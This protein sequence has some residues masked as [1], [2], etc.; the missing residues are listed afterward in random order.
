MCF[1]TFFADQ[2]PNRGPFK[3]EVFSNLIFQIALIGK[4]EQLCAVDKAGKGR[5]SSGHLGHVVNLQALA[6]VRRRLH[7]GGRVVEHIVEHTGGDAACILLVHLFNQLV[8]VVDPLTGLG[9]DEQHRRIRHKAEVDVQL[10]FHLLHGLIGLFL[11]RIPLVDGDD[12][13]LALLMGIACNLGIL[14]AEALG[15]VSYTH[16]V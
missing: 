13:R 4:M 10:L 9:R 15:P 5:W 7:A 1:V 2:H 6:L 11:Q 14:L 3:A 12:A 16:L 8:Q